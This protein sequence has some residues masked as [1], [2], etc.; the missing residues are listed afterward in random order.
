[1]EAGPQVCTAMTDITRVTQ[2]QHNQNLS[3]NI[4]GI[5]SES[6][7]LPDAINS[8]LTAIQRETGFDAVGIRLRSG[9]DFPCF[10]QN[11]FSND[12]LL[13][14]NTLTVRDQHGGVCRDKDGKPFLE[15]TCGLV[16]SGKTDPTNPLFTPGGKRLDKQLPPSVRPSC[17]PGPKTSSTQPLHS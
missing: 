8:I 16:I 13:T 2:A 4:L 9:D 11:G 17:S 6:V 14:E 3:M 12:F 15:C 5:L 10:V 7:A 1:M